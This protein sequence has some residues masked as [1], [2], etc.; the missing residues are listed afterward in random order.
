MTGGWTRDSRRHV[1]S[2]TE[3]PWWTFS[4]EDTR[5]FSTF[6]LE[7][8]FGSSFNVSFFLRSLK[9]DGLLFQL[10]RPPPTEGGVYF[11]V[12][13]GMGRIFISSLP[14]GSSLS[15]PIF[16]TTGEKKLL[17][18]E[19]QQSQVV[20]E[21]AGLRYTVG[22]IP[23]VSVSAGDQ[24]FIGG[25]P[26]NLD[27]GLWGGHYKGCLQDLRFNSVHLDLEAWDQVPGP[28]DQER[29]VA[30][31]AASIRRGCISD[32]TCK[33]RRLLLVPLVESIQRQQEVLHLSSLPPFS[34]L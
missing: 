19:V 11:S 21:H 27:S 32:D 3:F 34:V 13:L 33:V 31:E 23:E 18:V 17:R 24:A 1:P 12:Y 15:A 30:R 6:D 2:L 5:S 28:E 20:F 10:R 9:L 16:V 26:A 7:E 22:Q 4:H 8:T 14:H 29:N 25:L